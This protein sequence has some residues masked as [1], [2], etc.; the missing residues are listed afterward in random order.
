[1]ETLVE[2]VGKRR[3]GAL[4]IV[5][6]GHQ[7]GV[8]VG[9]E[10]VDVLDDENALDGFGYL[11]HRRQFGVGEN[12]A[13]YPRVDVEV[14]IHLTDGVQQKQPIVIEAAAR[15]FHVVPVIPV[16]DVLEHA[17][18]GDAVELLVDVSIVLQANVYRQSLAP[19]SCQLGLLSRDRHANGLDAIMFGGIAH[20]AAPTTADV[21]QPHAGFESEFAAD[22]RELVILRF[23]QR[24]GPFPI[25]AG[26]GH[27]VV[28]H[29]LV[30]IIVE[31]VVDLG[32]HAGAAA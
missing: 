16:T 20:Q 8:V 5:V 11:F 9:A 25:A 14:G 31:I 3:P 15:D 10:A 4:E 2:A 30:E 32:H 27:V 28:E 13:L 6:P 1:M 12:I 7:R 18:A 23:L 24:F 17:D 19:R 26:V 21:E 22:E 29:G